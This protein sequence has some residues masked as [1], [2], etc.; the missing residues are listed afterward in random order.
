MPTQQD[1]AII[2]ADIV[3]STRLY[4]MLGDQ[5][6]LDIVT[7][8]LDAMT[9]VAEARGGQLV[10]TIGDAVMIAF[11][12][13]EAAFLAAIDMRR[14]I[15]ALAP[16]QVGDRQL[17]LRVRIGLHFGAA[18]RENRDLYGDAVNVASRMCDMA[19]AGQILTTGDLLDALPLH[20]RSLG[21]AFADIEVKGR[22]D[23]VRAVRVADESAMQENTLVSYGRAP[24][25]PDARAVV[26]LRHAGRIWTPQADT[27]R[28]L[29][30]REAGCDLIL[31]GSLASRQHATIE[32]RRSKVVLIDHSSNGTCLILGTDRPIRLRRE[33][34]GLIHAGSIIFGT[35]EAPDAD[36][37]EFS[38]G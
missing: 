35:M 6:A 29:C 28:I 33:E 36:V 20:L 21:S 19:S 2:F 38:I 11:T 31:K 12:E 17:R 15:A 14:A 5:D 3:G 24:D 26:T 10:K 23:P 4:E 8:C 27:R 9:R 18:L 22:S 13:P 7:A 32:I 30:G 1:H 34:F 16:V 37:L 25:A